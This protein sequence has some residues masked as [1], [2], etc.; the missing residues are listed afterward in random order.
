MPDGPVSSIHRSLHSPITARRKKIRSL[1][2]EQVRV[3]SIPGSLYWVS[4]TM[5][6][7]ALR[8]DSL[9]HRHVLTLLMIQHG[10][11][12]MDACDFPSRHTPM[13]VGSRQKKLRGVAFSFL[14]TSSEISSL[15]DDQCRTR[16]VEEAEA[17]R[18]SRPG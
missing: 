6:K 2:P 5:R 1:D 14:K 18:H 4:R 9:I 12:S 11:R 15:D 16:T 7:R 13:V 8:S 17:I 10:R 3:K